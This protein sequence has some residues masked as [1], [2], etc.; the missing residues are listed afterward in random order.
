MR[1]ASL[2]PSATEL[3]AGLGATDDLVAR[4][5]QCNYPSEIRDVPVVTTSTL[6]EQ[7]SSDAYEI[8]SVV[9]DHHHGD[10]TYFQVITEDLQTVRPEVLI[11]QSLC[12][13]CAVPESMT[14]ESMEAL[15][16]EPELVSLGPTTI[17]EI[18]DAINR[19]GTVLDRESDADQLVARLQDR[20]DTIL[21]HRPDPSQPPQVVCLEWTDAL[22][23]H[24]LW[25][26]EIIELLGAEDSFGNPGEHGRVIEWDDIV[27]Y[28]PEVLLVSPCGRTI[29][30]I[31]QDM[32]HVV[33]RP[34]WSELAAVKNDRVY[35]LNGEISSRHGPRV[36]RALE[37]VAKTLYPETF[38]D[39][40]SASDELVHFRLSSS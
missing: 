3:V 17:N 27:A 4:S 35:L 33:N 30:E 7:A 40:S 14:A 12:D 31:Q 11:T 2:F 19:L 36:V 8:D 20:V 28:D 5:H 34:G 32:E 6:S 16:S 9:D 22:R 18:L 21:Q 1:T 23:C 38:A 15:D 26:P 39:I 13:V 37:L 25:M 24:G 29:P 10:S